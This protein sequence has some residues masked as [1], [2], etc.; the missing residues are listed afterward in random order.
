MLICF[1]V[2]REIY[3]HL[4]VVGDYAELF[5]IGEHYGERGRLSSGLMGL[6]SP[7]KED[8]AE[9]VNNLLD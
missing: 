8:L 9:T 1:L 7:A 2:N 5:F 6:A 3:C 4:D